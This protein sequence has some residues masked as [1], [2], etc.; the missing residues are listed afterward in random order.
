MNFNITCADSDGAGGPGPAP[1]KK[2][3]NIGFLSNTSPDPVK[4]HKLPSQHSM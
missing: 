4:T 2:Y 3:K 1:C